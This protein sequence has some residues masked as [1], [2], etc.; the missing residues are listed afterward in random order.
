M[1]TMERTVQL[2]DEA[3]RLLATYAEEHALSV[4]ELLTRYARRL[5]PRAPHPA[6][7][8]FTGTVPADTD[9]R[10]EHRQH[11]ERKHR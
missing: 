3:A 4:A 5:Q 8:E 7:L 10:A 9:A 1:K 11:L 2:P 6:N